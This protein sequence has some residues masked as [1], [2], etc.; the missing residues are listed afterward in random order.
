MFIIAYE[1][2]DPHKITLCE[3]T[4]RDTGIACNMGGG[5]LLTCTIELAP[6]T[7]VP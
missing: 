3:I 1:I 5:P 7:P 2:S 4:A 6:H